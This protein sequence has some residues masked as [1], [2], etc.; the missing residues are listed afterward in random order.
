MSDDGPEAENGGES[1]PRKN[2]MRFRRSGL[3]KLD[4]DH[5]QRQG[6]ITRMAID[7]LGP[8]AAIQF[9]NQDNAEL[10]ARP[11]DI[12]IASGEGRALVEAELQRLAA[13]TAPRT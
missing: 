2:T 1:P 11:L 5:A 6:D 8:V 10:G 12:A 7:L 13:L 9:L 4:R 3:P